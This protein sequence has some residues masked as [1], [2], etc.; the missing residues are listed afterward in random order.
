MSIT[1]P[2][3]AC[4]GTESPCVSFRALPKRTGKHSVRHS[5]DEATH[6]AEVRCDTEHPPPSPGAL[7]NKSDTEHRLRSSGARCA[8]LLARHGQMT[9][10]RMLRKTNQGYQ[11]YHVG[12][13]WCTPRA[14]LV[15]A[16]HCRQGPAPL[17]DPTGREGSR[18]RITVGY[19]SVV[20]GPSPVGGLGNLVRKSRLIEGPHLHSD[21][22]GADS[23]AASSTGGGSRLARS[24]WLWKRGQRRKNWKKRWHV[25]DPK[26]KCLRCVGVGL[27]GPSRPRPSPRP[28]TSPNGLR[29]LRGPR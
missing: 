4:T 17:E 29:K 28:P 23:S 19:W 7:P 16:P 25:I 27:S 11:E 1:A 2:A 21:M 18:R 5:V 10:K 8:R 26:D 24:G 12:D 6:A 15:S 9:T 13:Q 3:V 14:L 22:S 20:V